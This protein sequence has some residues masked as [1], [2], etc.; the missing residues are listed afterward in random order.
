M[1][2]ILILSLALVLGIGATAQ[3]KYGA[4]AGVN[5]ATLSEPEGASFDSKVGFFVGGLVNF[6]FSEIIGLQPEVV[7]STQ[8][9]KEDDSSLNFN[10]INVPILLDI[11]PFENFSVL[12]GPQIG[13]NVYKSAKQGGVSISGSDFEDAIGKVNT[14]DFGAALGVQYAILGHFVISARYNL[15]F[16]KTLKDAEEGS[17]NRVFQFGIGYTF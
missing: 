15:G 10:Y 5:V 4:K 6:S 17:A 1:K 11:K 12:V 9:A 8:G 16:T 14:I 13:I 3:V 2:K 7:F